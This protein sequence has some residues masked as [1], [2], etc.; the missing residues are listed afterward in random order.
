VSLDALPA[1]VQKEA[2]SLIHF[3]CEVDWNEDHRFLKFELPTTV[4]A[5]EAT[6]DA[7]FGVVK[8]PTY[9]NTT[10]DSARFEV[11]AHKFADRES[12]VGSMGPNILV[13]EYGY[14]VAILNDCKYGYAVQGSVMRL[15][16]LRSPTAPDETCDRGN[17]K[18]SFA[19]YPHLGTYAESDV[20]QVAHIFNN[21][22]LGAS[23]KMTGAFADSNPEIQGS[24]PSSSPLSN[25][26]FIVKGAPNVMFETVKRGEEDFDALTHK[27]TG[28][29]SIIMRLFEHMGG[30]AS[31]KISM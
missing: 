23:L 3:D 28:S 22:L 24:L 18:F 11:C 31:A 30:S 2:R 7:A 15:S 12:A 6:Y 10:W 13:S 16:L 9:R 20:H 17:Q 27:P 14:G 19:I 1:S 8:R 4:W 25:F 29:K 26:P 5:A 21:P